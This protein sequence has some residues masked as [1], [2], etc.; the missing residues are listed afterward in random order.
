MGHRL[1]DGF[2]WYVPA[3]GGDAAPE[4]RYREITEWAAKARGK[5]PNAFDGLT[6]W[7]LDNEEW[8]TDKLERNREIFVDGI[9]RRFQRQN[10]QLREILTELRPFEIVNQAAFGA[11]DAFDETLKG[12]PPVDA[13]REPVAQ[14][15]RDF[16][17]MAQSRIRKQIAGN[18]T[19]PSGTDTVE[20]FGYV[21]LLKE[22]DARVQWTLFMPDMVSRQQEGFRMQSFEYKRLPALR[23]IGQEGDGL[24]NP[25]KRAALFARLDAMSQYRSGFDYDLLF[26]H[27]YCLGVDISPW[28][29]FWGRFMKADAP[30]PEGLVS[31]DLVPHHDGSP[32][33]PF[34]SQ[35]AYAVFSGDTEALHRREGFDSGAMYDVTRNVILSQDVCIPYP[36][37][38]WTAEV[39]FQGSQKESSGYLFS[40]ILDE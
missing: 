1:A 31:F 28:H 8:T 5:N 37:K 14:M 29:G 13:L 24:A 26:M 10:A 36:E 32:G 21:N 27:H 25:E 40:V 11:L 19:G 33:M 4:A 18:K 38:Y 22:C 23:F 15:T 16:S 17:V 39:F 7:M 30:V 6:Q 3:S 2:C 9:V 20:V 12:D 34:V 35:F